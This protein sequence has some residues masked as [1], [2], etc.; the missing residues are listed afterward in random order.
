[1]DINIQLRAEVLGYS[2]FIEKMVNDLL[3]LNL[4]ISDEKGNTRLFSNKGK[5]SFQHKIDL[6]YDIEVLSKEENSDFELLM[7]I[8]NKFMHDIECNSFNTLLN[9]LDNGIVNRFNKF[10]EVGQLNSSEESCRDA[11]YR[12]FKN[13]LGVIKKK[14]KLNKAVKEKK[15]KLFQVQNEQIVYYI[16]AIHAVLK[17]ISIVTEK[18]ELENPKVAILGEEILHILDETVDKLN[19]ETEK[20]IYEEFFNSD[21]DIKAIF[22]IKRGL[23][24]LP[25]WEDFK[26]P[27]IIKPKI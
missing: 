2:L 26:L 1:M 27:K 14:I 3:L 25:K 12:I 13:N 6:L 20:D 22:G 19:V 8:R 18:S 5:I 16:D 11:Y 4:G 21:D 10:L 23:K 9:Q 17:K 7:I 15:F 24:D